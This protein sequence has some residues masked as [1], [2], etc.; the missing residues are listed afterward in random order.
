MRLASQPIRALLVCSVL[1]AACGDGGGDPAASSNTRIRFVVPIE[2]MGCELDMDIVCGN[3]NEL[4]TLPN[5]CSNDDVWDEGAEWL[6]F[7]DLPP[8]QCTFTV[9]IERDGTVC[10][11]AQTFEVV[12]GRQV[13]VDVPVT[14][15]P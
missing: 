8:R 11:G 2:A 12:L 6:G 13:M 9:S 1:C 7:W 14:C 3:P 15:T 4:P 10:E 5:V